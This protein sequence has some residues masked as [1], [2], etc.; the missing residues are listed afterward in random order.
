MPLEIEDPLLAKRTYR[1]KRCEYCRGKE[2][3]PPSEVKDALRRTK[4]ETQRHEHKLVHIVSQKTKEGV[5]RTP[6]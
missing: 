3:P 4:A 2:M 1:E 5:I 6:S